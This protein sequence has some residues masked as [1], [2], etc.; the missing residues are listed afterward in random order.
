SF[1]H[2]YN[3]ERRYD[4]AVLEVS[5]DGSPYVDLVDAGGRFVTGGYGTTLNDGT[6]NPIG[7][8]RAWSGDS[9]GWMTTVAT[10]P[11]AAAGHATRLRFRTADDA[12]FSAD[13]DNGWWIDSVALGVDAIPPNASVAPASLAFQ[14]DVGA[15]ATGA[16][17][18]SNAAG[19][20]PLAFSIETRGAAHATLMPYARSKTGT[21]KANAVRVAAT[22]GS[23]TIARTP[24]AG[25]PWMP[26]GSFTLQ[27]DDGSAETALG[28]GSASGEQGAVYLN[29]YVASDAMTI[30]SIGVYW[31]SGDGD[32][33]GLQANLVAYYDADGDGDPRN[34]MRLGVDTLVPIGSTGT[35]ETYAVDFE[36]PAG[37]DVYL[38][39]V[40][41]WAIAGQFLPR[42]FPAALDQSASQGRSYISS[43]T[44][45]PVDLSNL[46]NNDITGTIGDVEQGALD[47]NFMIRAVATGR[48]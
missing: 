11:A 13:G 31:P 40:D 34:A 30:H 21:G 36:V 10:L 2:R 9:Q 20:A 25:S 32:L 38:G 45:P 17:V 26:D 46:G 28:A 8:R 6:N 27:L 37:G 41:Q 18:L 4:G 44:T 5:I 43:A 23:R 7:G 14:L 15:S 29:R 1:R 39:F 3:L 48:R 19:S 12:S 16:V 24:R 42:L 33:G 35:F 47:G 22:I